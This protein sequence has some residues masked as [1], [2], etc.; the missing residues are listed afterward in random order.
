LN[1][2]FEVR[3]L[4]LYFGQIVDMNDKAKR[5]WKEVA[6]NFS[7]LVAVTKPMKELNSSSLRQRFETI[8]HNTG[9]G[10]MIREGH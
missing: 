8:P 3:R 5:K 1:T 2:G 4:G 9:G 7:W 6:Y 10:T